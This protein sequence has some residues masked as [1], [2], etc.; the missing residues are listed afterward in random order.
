MGFLFLNILSAYMCLYSSCS[1]ITPDID[2]SQV[3]KDIKE[4]S[5]EEVLLRTDRDRRTHA[6]TGN[7]DSINGIANAALTEVS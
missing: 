5:M 1:E 4:R 3:I 6:G 7:N 2:V